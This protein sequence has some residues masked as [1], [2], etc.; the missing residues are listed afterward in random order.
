MQVNIGARIGQAPPS[1]RYSV[2]YRTR[3]KN[4]WWTHDVLKDKPRAPAK[5]TLIIK[6][7]V[8]LECQKLIKQGR[9]HHN[10]GNC[11]QV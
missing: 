1:D 9:Y 2:R 11:V 8:E 10:G 7:K 6:D 3:S 5:G 4:V